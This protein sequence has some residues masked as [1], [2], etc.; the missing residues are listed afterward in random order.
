[1]I[2]HINYIKTLSEHLEAVED[3]VRGKDLVIILISSLPDEYNY[4]ITAL[5][6]ITEDKLTW[7]YVRDR[8]I[9]EADKINK[10]KDVGVVREV[11]QDALFTRRQDRKKAVDK[12]KD[13]CH[14]CKRPGHF[15]RDCY[16]KK[17]DAKKLA[18][19]KEQKG[20]ESH[21]GASGNFAN[22][23]E[24]NE[25]VND[26]DKVI[27]PDVALLAGEKSMKSEWWIDSGASQHMTPDKKSLI[28]FERFDSPVEVK[29]ADNSI[30]FS[31]GKGDVYLA[32]YDGT[33]KV[34]VML[35]EVL[36]VP[37]IQNKLLSLPSMTEK[38]AT[39]EFKGQSCKISIHG[40]TYS[41][42]H[43]HGKL[44]KLN[45]VPEDQ[46]CCL[47]TAESKADSLSLW[48][49]RY[50]HLGYD[51][52]KLLNGKDM[53]DGMKIKSAEEVDRYSCEGCAMG[54]QHHQ[55]FPKK[56]HHK[57]SKP[58]ELIHSD[59][60]GPMSVPS[61]G[62]SRFFVTF[63]DDFSRYTY[64]YIIKHKSEVLEKFQEFVKQ[65][66]NLTG[67]RVKSLRSDNESEYESKA[68]KEYCKS[69]GIMKEDTI[70]YT[71]QQNG[72]AERANRTIME[73]VRSMLYHAHLPLSFWGEAVSTAVY[74]KNRSPTSC[75]KDITPFECWFNKRPDVSNIKVFGCKVYVHVPDQKRRK[76]DKKSIPCV[77]VGYPTNSKGYKLYNLESKQM[78][79]S[80][81]VIFLENNF[82]HKLPDC[83]D[84]ELKVL[85]DE[86]KVKPD[87]VY[88]NHD[89]GG[90]YDEQLDN[91]E[92]N[93]PEV[94]PV[95]P[96]RNRVAPNRLG[97][98]TGNW[99][100]FVASVATTDEIEPK[101]INE[102]Y[103]GSNSKQWKEATH[104]EFE[105][106][107]K[108]HT[109]DLVDLPDGKN[110][111]GCKWIYKI[112]R[113]AD[114]DVSRYK[115]RL[116]AQGYS[117]VEGMDYEEVF[118]PVAR[119]NSI[120]SILAIANELDLDIHQTDVKCAF[121]HGE[122]DEEIYMEQPEGFI[123]E[124]HPNKVCRL[125]K[126]I[127]GLK[128][129]ARCW[130]SAIDKCV[131][132]SGYTQ[133]DA[134]PCIYSKSVDVDGKKYIMLIA[135]Y[136]DDI[137]LASNNADMM[138]EEKAKLSAQFEMEDQGEI[139]YC[140]GM[141]IKRDREEK[142]LSIDQKAYLEGVLKRFKM[143]DCKP[144]S[145]PLEAGKRFEKLGDGEETVD[146][147][148]YQAV[149]GCITY[150]S[151]ATRPDLSAA[152]GALSQFMSN[153]GKEHW[154]GVKR[155]LRY[156]KGTLNYGLKFESTNNGNVDLS[157]FADA[158]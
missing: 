62:G 152:I 23:S 40:K 41:I 101:N 79:R 126:S 63:I 111:V 5:E 1:M 70:P 33:E 138:K 30:L 146:V 26:C 149:I 51:N 98:I 50:G 17:N 106:L 3:P 74:L 73:T 158:D 61:V 20:S 140:L 137:L 117:Q 27:T 130:N 39:V 8:L 108:N 32:V 22:N 7:D 89:I 31:Y 122:L 44:Y 125:Q 81:D 88:F 132:D 93:V 92:N 65:T 11:T 99:W 121:L 87:S 141:S 120:R 55:P 94:E 119:Y 71:P 58:L 24:D 49:L 14:Y 78:I 113:N 52:V 85:V 155:V 64:V 103:S 19:E 96:Q 66:E 48:H 84:E 156:I 154:S 153:P 109:W 144:V 127:Y 28:N 118:A 35:K 139:H 151:V 83:K 42:G 97:V 135:V 80:R 21:A 75:L 147:K 15:A 134:D 4:L 67:L 116:V 129:S 29:L 36:Y 25:V 76:L 102:A 12:R 38:G 123:D 148:E 56:S 53:V 107:T 68:F 46:T 13:V 90:V 143:N 72:I 54:K 82:D 60:C 43:K 150:A 131:K 10:T 136:V 69:K 145:T 100:D 91:H 114:G 104:S 16:K 2:N 157:G 57:R 105:S 142:V 18:Q 128:Q 47:G 9:Y 112:K 95:R 45:S 6:T 77:F 110:V 34:N 59:V 115:A 133:S 86:K 124:N 37:K